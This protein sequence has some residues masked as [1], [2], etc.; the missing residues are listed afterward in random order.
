MLLILKDFL[1][2]IL[3]SFAYGFIL[4]F[5]FTK[6]FKEKMDIPFNN[7]WN[8]FVISAF[9]IPFTLQR[10]IRYYDLRK[11]KTI[12][13]AELII[14]VLSFV[15]AKSVFK[16]KIDIMIMKIILVLFFIIMALKGC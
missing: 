13:I 14:L 16:P 5:L 2:D 7:V 3:G 4:L 15:Y 11:S 10:L 6:M 8:K 9:L 1:Q 12:I